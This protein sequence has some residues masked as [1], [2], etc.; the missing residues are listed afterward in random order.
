MQIPII[1]DHLVDN[2]LKVGAE[3]KTKS[4]DVISMRMN[5]N[6]LFKAN[7]SLIECKGTIIF[8]FTQCD[9]LRNILICTNH[10][11]LTLCLAT[12]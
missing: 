12:V 7:K 3:R 8:F 11:P 5:D 1:A 10:V 9:V 6:P 2:V 4:K